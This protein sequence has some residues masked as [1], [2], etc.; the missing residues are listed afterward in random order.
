MQACRKI[1]LRRCI[2]LW[3]RKKKIGGEERGNK[4]YSVQKVMVG[5][6]VVVNN[7]FTKEL[8]SF[9]KGITSELVIYSTIRVIFTC[10]FSSGRRA[11]KPS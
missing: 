9:F 2:L 8:N 3:K 1:K 11:I 7:L 5:I 4:Y 6:V 10:I